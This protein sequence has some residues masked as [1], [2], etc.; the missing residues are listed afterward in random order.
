MEGII[1]NKFASETFFFSTTAATLPFKQWHY[2]KIIYLLVAVIRKLL[3]RKW[4]IQVEKS[5]LE[6]K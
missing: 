5:K 6:E 1:C 3:I 2:Q 4:S